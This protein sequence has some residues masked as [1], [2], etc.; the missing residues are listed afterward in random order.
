MLRWQHHQDALRYF[1]LSQ[2]VQVLLVKYGQLGHTSNGQALRH[3]QQ[4]RLIGCSQV[5]LVSLWISKN[6]IWLESS[7]LITV[8]KL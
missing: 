5:E 6:R 3:R 4:E 2:R 1:L 7:T 8:A